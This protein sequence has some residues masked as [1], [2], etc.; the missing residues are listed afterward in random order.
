MH[1]KWIWR[2]NHDIS[3]SPGLNPSPIFQ[4]NIPDLHNVPV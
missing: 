2:L 3:I 1:S 4:R